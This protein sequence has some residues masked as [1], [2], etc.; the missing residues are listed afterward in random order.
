MRVHRNPTV[1]VDANQNLIGAESD[2]N[3]TGAKPDQN[4]TGAQSDQNLIG[5][6]SDQNLL[7]SVAETTG[8]V[9][10]K[11]SNVIGSLTGALKSRRK[12]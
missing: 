9:A 8:R 6:E 11:V 3:L 10:A 5:A 7:T 12:K 4:L 2:Q 1:K